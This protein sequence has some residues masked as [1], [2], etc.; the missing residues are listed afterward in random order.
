MTEDL[1]EKLARAG[2][3]TI[4]I[5]IESGN[6]RIREKIL[7]KGIKKD[8]IIKASEAIRKYGLKFR[9]YNMIGM[10]GETIDQAYETIELNS[11]IKT[12][13]PWAS[14][15]QPYP[16]THL[17]DYAIKNGYVD[18]NMKREDFP[19][20][21]F[22]GSIINQ[23]NIKHLVNIQKLFY[24]LV[25]FPGLQKMSRRFVKFPLYWFFEGVFSVTYI[26]C[27]A[28]SYNLKLWESF[29]LALRMRNLFRK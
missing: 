7:K 25:K 13:Y 3:I 1:M 11:L 24:L 15:Y 5:G 23:E 9:T 20:S 8:D 12:D 6:D 10:P 19:I 29:F 2:C 27:T 26:V 17:G 22:K 18:E 16:R 28:S 14:I 4:S 21:F